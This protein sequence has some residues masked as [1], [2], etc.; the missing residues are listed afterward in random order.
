MKPFLLAGEQSEFGGGFLAREAWIQPASY[1]QP[2]SLA[3]IEQ[4][5]AQLQVSFKSVRE[6][7]PRRIYHA[8]E[9]RRHSHNRH[10]AAVKMHYLPDNLRVRFKPIAP[11]PFA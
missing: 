8:R 10:W 11:Q 7:C 6:P 3:R 1:H 4:V 9:V 5:V 2:G